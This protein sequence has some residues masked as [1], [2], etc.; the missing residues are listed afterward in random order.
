M[1]SG[2]TR[3]GALHATTGTGVDSLF[4][5]SG[6]DTLVSQDGAPDYVSCGSSVDTLNRDGQDQVLVDCERLT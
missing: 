2:T 4:G 1:S 5:D 6:A 3:R